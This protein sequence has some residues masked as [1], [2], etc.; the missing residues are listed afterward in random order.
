MEIQI[1]VV[2]CVI[3]LHFPVRLN[4]L[5]HTAHTNLCLPLAV[6]KLLMP[7]LEGLHRWMHGE[8]ARDAAFCVG[9][10]ESLLDASGLWNIFRLSLSPRLP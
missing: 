2:M 1:W 6:A 3:S 5:Y 7:G 8:M 10:L 9:Q 4:R